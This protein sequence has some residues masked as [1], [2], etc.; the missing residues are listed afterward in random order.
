MTALPLPQDLIETDN[1]AR[2]VA[3][4]DDYASLGRS[5]DRRGVAI[6]RIKDE[7][8]AFAVAVPTWGLGIGGT[9]FA[10]FPLPGEPTNIHENLVDGIAVPARV[11]A[12]AGDASRSVQKRWSS[13][14]FTGPHRGRRRSGRAAEV[15]HRFCSKVVS[16]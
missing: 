7:V 10:K 14:C 1:R 13:R 2:L 4:E 15:R 11:R 8:K 9:R 5:L 3:L 12:V 6:D 16:T